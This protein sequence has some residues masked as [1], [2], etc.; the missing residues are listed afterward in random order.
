ME[1]PMTF[2]DLPP[3][4][5]QDQEADLAAE[6]EAIG[7]DRYEP[8][9][10]DLAGAW[11]D[12]PAD[13]ADWIGDRDAGLD[14]GWRAGA[15]VFGGGFAEGGVLDRLGLLGVIKDAYVLRVFRAFAMPMVQGDHRQGGACSLAAAACRCAGMLGPPGDLLAEFREGRG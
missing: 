6:L 9:D 8:S 1:A 11:T 15:P 14:D 5:W 4:P 12:R 7:E 2:P 13:C 10:E 3:G